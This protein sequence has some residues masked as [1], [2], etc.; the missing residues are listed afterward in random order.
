[1]TRIVVFVAAL[2]G[3]MTLVANSGVYDQAP[4]PACQGTSR[5]LSSDAECGD[6]DQRLVMMRSNSAYYRRCYE[7]AP[8][9]YCDGGRVDHKDVEHIPA[10]KTVVKDG[11]GRHAGVIDLPP[12]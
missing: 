7:S 9:P 4:C 11:H 10:G 5:V 3:A 6:A 1:M 2:V 8:C 12:R